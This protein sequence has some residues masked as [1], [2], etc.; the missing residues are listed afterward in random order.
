M[1][2]P[3]QVQTS[4]WTSHRVFPCRHRLFLPFLGQSRAEEWSAPWRWH[5]APGQPGTLHTPEPR[6]K[7]PPP[8]SCQGSKAGRRGHHWKE[9]KS[10]SQG[11]SNTSCL[12]WQTL[13]QTSSVFLCLFIS[14]CNAEF[15]ISRDTQVSWPF[16]C[17]QDKSLCCVIGY[18]SFSVSCLLM[19]T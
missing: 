14:P 19:K 18:L 4:W 6:R 9:R 17:C 16:S 15:F 7:H 11:S 3:E 2:L 10:K 13:E 5:P 8:E 1:H 12:D